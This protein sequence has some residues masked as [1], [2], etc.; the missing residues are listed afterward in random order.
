MK[1]TIELPDALFRRAKARAA[2]RGLSLKELFTEALQAELLTDAPAASATAP[3]WMSGFG[4]LRA[5]AEETARIQRT[6][7]AEFESID[8]EDRA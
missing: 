2:E 5:L 3:P 4:K 1:T 8:A 6:I 7:D